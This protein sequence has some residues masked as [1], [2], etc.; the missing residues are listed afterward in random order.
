MTGWDD[1]PVA[2][3]LTPPLTT[4]AQPLVAIGREA[5]RLILRRIGGSEG[6][7]EKVVLETRVVFRASCGCA[8]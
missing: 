8:R 6:D 7:P 5:A 2:R 1:I 3:F 4:V